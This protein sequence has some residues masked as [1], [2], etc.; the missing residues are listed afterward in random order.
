MIPI[1][2]KLGDVDMVRLRD[3]VLTVPVYGGT[4]GDYPW[5]RWEAAARSAGVSDDLANLGRALFRE[6]FSTNG[7]ILSRWNADGWMAASE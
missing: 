4:P 2:A 6:P 7:M 3:R 5:D 1:A